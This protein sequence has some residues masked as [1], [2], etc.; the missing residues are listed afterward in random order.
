[1]KNLLNR[2]GDH[3]EEIGLYQHMLN[4][5]IISTWIIVMKYNWSQK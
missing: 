1:M 3:I 5:M 4:V 2:F